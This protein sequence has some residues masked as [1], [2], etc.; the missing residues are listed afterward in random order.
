M[1]LLHTADWHLGRTLYGRKRYEEFKAFLGWL[2]NAIEKHKIDVLLIAGDVFDTGTPSNHA[3]QLYYNFLCKVSS[4]CCQHI[5]VIAGNHDSPSFLNAPRQI[6][7]AL[8]VHVVGAASENRE[9]E[10]INIL[11]D[12]RET[13][14]TDKERWP[15]DG[16]QD[17][18]TNATSQNS[19][20][21]N[22]IICAVPY[23]R[24]RDVR[25]AEPGET[26][27]QKNH[28]LI[29]GIKAHYAEVVEI[30]KRKREE[31]TQ[32][33]KN[34]HLPVPIIAM[35]HLFTAGGKTVEG[36]GVRELYAGSLAHI[37]QEA[38]PSSI[39]YLALGHLHVPQTVGHTKHIRYSGSPLPMG[40][41]EANQEKKVLLIDFSSNTPNIQ[42]IPLPCFQ[43]LIRIEGCR[44]KISTTLRELKNKNSQAWLEIE[45]T[46]K[47]PVGNLRE[48]IHDLLSGSAM[49]IRRIKNRQITDRVINIASRNETLDDLD[50]SDIF[51]RCLDAFEVP[52]EDRA[53]LII[54]YNEIIREMHE[55]D[56]NAD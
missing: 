55:D 37:G 29:A 33:N 35:G 1:R 14:S 19:T 34:P 38:F 30:A 48:T 24:D 47:E 50:H 5:V 31:I 10:V 53:E 21:G 8:N 6:L 46:G 20:A 54:S 45:Y 27:D 22:A 11:T 23:L 44:E 32:K 7:Q 2:V 16:L 17:F 25:I 4:S 41:G 49:E 39:D 15:E 51:N 40:F 3:Q 43:Q 9:D 18:K 36:D 42:E 26:I 12:S 56:A 28:K 52:A 13:E